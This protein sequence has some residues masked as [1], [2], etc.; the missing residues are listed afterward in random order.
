MTDSR[1]FYGF[2]GCVRNEQ[3]A[4]E[5]IN[6]IQKQAHTVFCYRFKKPSGFLCLGKGN[7]TLE[8]VIIKGQGQLFVYFDLFIINQLKTFLKRNGRREQVVE[9]R[10]EVLVRSLQISNDTLLELR[11]KVTYKN[12]AQMFVM[13]G[14]LCQQDDVD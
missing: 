1:K 6:I 2:Q 12:G 14:H 3:Y 13:S 7:R 9:N 11:K 5:I 8:D 4:P 10:R